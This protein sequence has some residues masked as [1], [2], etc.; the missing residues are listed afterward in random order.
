MVNFFP[1]TFPAAF[2]SSAIK[3]PKVCFIIKLAR[4]NKTAKK[5]KTM[6]KALAISFLSHQQ[7]I[8]FEASLETFFRNRS[9]KFLTLL[10]LFL[11]FTISKKIILKWLPWSSI[12]TKIG[13]GLRMKKNCDKFSFVTKLQFLF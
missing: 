9:D 13:K 8:S 6:K 4:G 10:V 2:S 7:P 1:Q 5:F 12:L 11:P 3:D